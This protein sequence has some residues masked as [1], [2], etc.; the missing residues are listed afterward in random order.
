MKKINVMHRA[1]AAA[2]AVVLSAGVMTGCGKKDA[3]KDEQG[4]TIISVGG[5]PQKEGVALDNY[6]SRKE[7]FEKDNPDVVVEPNAWSFDR[8]SFY[9]KAAGGQL[10]TVFG[11]A[12]TEMPEIISSEYSADITEALKKRGYDGKFNK[13]VLDIVSKDGKIYAFPNNAYILG[14]GINTDMFEKAGLM[15][16]DGTPKQSKD[17][18]ELADFAVKIKE[19]TGKAGVVFPSA[20]GYGGWMFSCLAWSFGVDFMER[21]ADGKWKA[22]FNTPEAQEALQYIKDLKWKYKVL[23]G[24]SLVNGTEYY[25]T[26]AV[27]EAAMLM[28]AGDLPRNVFQYEMNRDSLG[29]IAMPAGPKKH[30]S[31]LGGTVFCINPDATDDQIDVALRWIET[32]THYDATE[33]FKTN[34]QDEM[35][36]QLEENRLIGVKSMSVWSS[37]ADSLKFEYGLIDKNRNVNENHVKLYNNFVADCPAEIQPEEPVCAQE[38]YKELDNCIQEVLLN[39][40]ADCAEILEKANT[41][42]QKNYLDNLTY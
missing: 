7:R 13:S 39:E 40:N 1:C 16:A 17:W 19:A 27:G 6:N 32:Q 42:F 21:D 3:S 30:V 26:F 25:K 5:W 22:T 36:K 18:Y 10:P 23:P 41:D 38:L 20:D 24:A 15:E 4:R 12:Y 33:E 2:L 28:A 29:M 37:S 31:L 9:A 35:K 34:A 11:V 14:L 8:K